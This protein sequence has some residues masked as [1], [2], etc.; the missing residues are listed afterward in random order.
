MRDEPLSSFPASDDRTER[1]ASAA[2][3][4]PAPGAGSGGS[5]VGP[6]TPWLG[7][8]SFTED[9]GAYFFGRTAELQDLYER[10]VHKPLTV[11]FGQSGLGKTSLLQAALVPR[12]RAAGYLPILM[13][14]DHSVGAPDLER[15]MITA[16]RGVI[17][18]DLRAIVREV[19]REAPAHSLSDPAALETAVAKSGFEHLVFPKDVESIWLLLHDPQ[20]GFVSHEGVCPVRPVFLFDQFEEIFTLGERG[21][22]KQDALLF[23]D[24]LACLV[25]NRAPEAVRRRV[26]TDDALAD[27]LVYQARPAKVLLTLREDF[28]HVLE[29]WRRQIPSLMD[30]RFELRLLT[31]LQA[32]EAVVEPGKRRGPDRPPIVS[33]ETGAAIVRFV[34]GAGTEMPLVEIDTVPP[35]LSLICSE[36]NARRFGPEG[37]PCEET[38]QPDQLLG[39]SEDI[40]YNFY[41]D[42]FQGVP[43][44]VRDLVEDRMLSADGFRESLALD[45]AHH[46]LEKEGMTLAEARA[47]IGALVDRRLLVVEE[48]GGVRRVELTHDILTGVARQSRDKR[49]AGEA[50][51][52]AEQANAAAAAKA[53]EQRRVI[54]RTR[55]IG[56]GF[57]LLALFSIGALLLALAQGRKAS[58]QRHEA[59]AQSWAAAAQSNKASS[60]RARADEAL[61]Q[62][63]KQIHQACLS[64]LST[65]RNLLGKGNWREAITYLRRAEHY[66]DPESQRASTWLWGEIVYGAGDRDVLP[67]YLLVHTDR[68]QSA[69]CSPDGTRIV[70]ASFD[71]TVR[72]WDAATGKP[73][74]AP[75]DHG[76]WVW[77]AAYSP[78]GARIVSTSRGCAWQWNAATGKLI[79]GIT[80]H[81]ERVVSAAYSPDGT[82]IVTASNDRTARQWNAATGKLIGEPLRHEASVCRA[83]YSPDG[84]RVVTASEDKTAR[85][86]DTFTG[87][88]IGEPFRHEDVVRSAVYSPDGSRVL[89]A[90]DDRTVRQWDAAT[91]QLIGEP[92]RHEYAVNTAAYSPDGQRIVTGGGGSLFE[93]PVGYVQEWDAATGKMIGGRMRHERGVTMASYSPDGLHII[94]A[95]DDNTTRLYGLATARPTGEPFRHLDSVWS[96][97]YSPDG[98]RIVTASRDKTARQWNSVTGEP[99][100]EPLRHDEG[101]QSAAYGP[102]GTRI[103]TAC[104]DKAVRQWDA[105]TGVP[106]GE[107]LRHQEK[108]SSACYR[109]DLACILTV[110]GDKTVRQWESR[111]GQL[112]GTPLLHPDGVTSAAYSHDGSRIVTACID[113]SVRQWD[114]ATGKLIGE[115]LRHDDIPTA[116]AYNPAGTRIVTVSE[117]KTARQWDA[118]TG[119]LV[120]AP[121]RHDYPV[122]TAEYSP[123]GCRI[124]TAGGASILEH[125][126][127]YAQE[128][129]AATG[130]AIGGY[131]RHEKSVFMAVYSPDG[132][133]ILTTSADQVVRQWECSHLQVPAPPW[134]DD[135]VQVLA[136][137]RFDEEGTLQNVPAAERVSMRAELLDKLGH[138]ASDATEWTRLASWALV[139]PIIRS[140]TPNCPSTTADIA[141]RERMTGTRDSIIAAFH[142]DPV[143]PLV[144]IGL[145]AL[146]ENKAQADF[147]RRYEIQRLPPDVETRLKAVNAFRHS[148]TA[149]AC[150][151]G[152]CR[153][154]QGK[155]AK[156]RRVPD[157]REHS[158]G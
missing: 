92:F 118:A 141:K 151:R 133:R 76:D 59:L 147:L 96:A 152:R 70:T 140:Y 34:A 156:R 104:D 145:S 58:A 43:I 142:L 21:E 86:W 47:A 93:E 53:A 67:E 9:T 154:Q 56:A 44:A 128:W 110:S 143:L 127:G 73:I 112:V 4:P 33:P 113:K 148:Q 94:T 103:V 119:K 129:D 137:L 91:G 19:T 5:G 102:G 22:R 135:L 100:G 125:P 84:R 136:G 89:T 37:N 131:L 124:V 81:E 26:E 132:S 114:A 3:V 101:V 36:L 61:E 109:P 12:L 45:T 88:P 62:T 111:T 83:A 155:P 18:H 115:P 13:R 15:Q 35:L 85:Q 66:D 87:K 32:L 90:S 54:R 39:R 126:F 150:A 16:F 157:R 24:A 107:P 134:F 65:A 57:A 50:A 30:N 108:V 75:I 82:R 74:G 41:R 2:S 52:R 23:R 31:G 48:R 149:T 42:S 11:L 7:L 17:H 158:Q 64:D 49:E 77:S 97:C 121:M 138:P 139:A 55:L 1:N 106:V 20:Y 116:A 153:D 105:A 14:L 79:G 122:H 63:R 80:G 78:D 38:I 29:R 25:E 98:T 40:L 69:A 117:D 120:G 6:E 51:M 144:H 130:K 95:C 71:Q 72:Q 10:I 123:D 8:R 28:L 68:V 99:V 146:E 27:R 46:L 60:A